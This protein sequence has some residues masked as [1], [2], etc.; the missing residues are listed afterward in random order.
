MKYLCF[1]LV[2]I[3]VIFCSNSIARDIIIGVISNGELIKNDVELVLYPKQ[4]KTAVDIHVNTYQR[5]HNDQ[6]CILENKR[7]EIHINTLKDTYTYA[8]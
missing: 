5:H 4:K 1:I 8:Y 6:E 3:E 7:T 2:H